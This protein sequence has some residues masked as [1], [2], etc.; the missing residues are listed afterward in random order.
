ME[1]TIFTQVVNREKD[2]EA[3]A[4]GYKTKIGHELWL[5]DGLQKDVIQNCWDARSDK[6]HGKNWKCGFSL[7]KISNK[8]IL[9]LADEG[10]T[11]LNGTKFY[12]PKELASIL[13]KVSNE[14][15][16]GEDLACFLNS[17]WSAKVSEEGGNRGRGKTLFLVVSKN[18]N[19]TL[20][21]FC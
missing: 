14:N 8:N 10:T 9:C 19:V 1:H 15:Q 12:S 13:E 4:D 2:I 6:K 21:L 11:G 17:N 18:K 3:V 16:R 5:A 20:F 7:M